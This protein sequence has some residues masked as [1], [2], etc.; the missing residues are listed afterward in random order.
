MLELGRQ[1]VC[2]CCS[3]LNNIILHA[4]LKDRWSW[5]SDIDEP[6]SIKEAYL[7]IAHNWGDRIR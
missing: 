4:N 7:F 6:C 5:R 1:V 2:G 3:L